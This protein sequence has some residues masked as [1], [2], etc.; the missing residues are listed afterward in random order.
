MAATME[1]PK[2]GRPPH[3]DRDRFHQYMWN[4]RRNGTSLLN[5]MKVAEL[6]ELSEESIETA[7][8]DLKAQGRIAPHKRTGGKGVSYLV[9]DP[10]TW[11]LED[12]STWVTPESKPVR[13]ILWE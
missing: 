8:R 12:E 1:K 6:L 3:I 13:R 9:A 5:T 4:I 7:V 11:D 2:R 10:D